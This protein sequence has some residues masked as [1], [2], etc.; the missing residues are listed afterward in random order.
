MF[1][2]Q[3]ERMATKTLRHKEAQSIKVDRK[4]FQDLPSQLVNLSTVFPFS[5]LHFS[6]PLNPSTI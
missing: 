1:N 3:V 4:L 6:F 2:F 5:I